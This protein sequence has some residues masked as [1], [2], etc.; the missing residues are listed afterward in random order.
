MA[1]ARSPGNGRLEEALATLVQNQA[2]YV[3]RMSEIDACVAE[4]ARLNAERFAG[5]DEQFARIE[6]L[7]IENTRLLKALPD[8]IREKLGFKPP[9]S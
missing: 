4:M 7:L 6:A 1:R 8:A 3:V 2:A 5:I 9:G